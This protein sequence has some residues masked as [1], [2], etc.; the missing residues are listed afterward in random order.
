MDIMQLDE[1]Y[2]ANTYHRFP[3]VFTKGKGSLI[4]DEAGKSYIDL[5]GG[6]A[7]NSFGIADPVWCEAVAGQ[8][9]CLQHVSNYYYTA[10]QTR[11]AAL[12]CEK[13]GMKK[14]FFS[15]SGAEANECAIKA[16]RKYG[17]DRSGGARNTIVTLKNSFHGRTLATL[18]A[19]GQ[20]ALHQHFGPFLPGFIYADA[21]DLE[22]MKEKLSDPA[23]CAVM[24]EM[25]QGEGGVNVLRKSFVRETARL[26]AEKDILVIVDEV[27]TGNG[28]C[29]SLYAYMQ[30]DIEPDIVSTAKGLGGGLP[31][32]ATLFGPKTQGVLSAGM[33]GSTFGGNPVCAAGAV[34]VLERMNQPL[35]N[36]VMAKS[37]FILRA[38]TGVPGVKSISGMGLML[39]IETE[40]PPQDIAAACLK[41]GVLVLT[42]KDKVRLLPALN[43]PME[44]LEQ[45]VDTLKQAI[46]HP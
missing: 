18:S 21:N 13:T 43:I 38:L 26:A 9:S 37:K 32:G 15:N 11:L 39:G 28:R 22:D 24:M 5:G 30:Y 46:L 45:A 2:I 1:Q 7:V 41:K 27:Q 12:L 17:N 8:L 44:L 6:I 34:S 16:A 3:V 31:L 42:A 25:V 19:T 29:G 10:P 20:E 35:M 36:A 14:V 23:V 33:H 40:A 4:W